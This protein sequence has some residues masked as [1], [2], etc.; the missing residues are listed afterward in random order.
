M[1]CAN[2]TSLPDLSGHYQRRYLRIS[3]RHRGTRRRLRLEPPVQLE[4]QSGG[5]RAESGGR[6]AC[7]YAHHAWRPLLRKQRVLPQPRRI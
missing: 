7:S 3:E 2:K 1:S 4:L 6:S 5:R